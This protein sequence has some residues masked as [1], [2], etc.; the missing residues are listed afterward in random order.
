MEIS[1]EKFNALVKNLQLANEN[2]FEFEILLKESIDADGFKR[3]LSKLKRNDEYAFVE[4]INRKQLDIRTIGEDSAVRVS[5]YGEDNIINYCKYNIISENT[6]VDIIVK[7]RVNNVDSVFIDEYNLRG[8]VSREEQIVDKSFKL[9]YINKLGNRD[10]FF[11]YKER[12]TFTTKTHKI[13]LTNIKSTPPPGVAKRL[14]SSKTLSS[15]IETFEVEVEALPYVE[16]NVATKTVLQQILRTSGILLKANR[17][18]DLLITKSEQD[19]VLRE[20]LKLVNPELSKIN[21]DDVK[22]NPGR[23]YLR[24]Q[25]VTLMKKNLLNKNLENATILDDYSVTEKADGDRMLFFINQD[26]DVFKIDNKLKFVKLNIKHQQAGSTIIDGEFVEKGKLEILLNMYLAFDIYFLAGED[27]RHKNLTDRL[28]LLSDYVKS[29]KWTNNANINISVKTF[30]TEKSVFENT[31]DVFDKISSL[32]YHTDGLIFTPINLSPGALYKNDTSMDKFGGTWSKVF[33][34]KPPEENSID[35]LVRLGNETYIQT[36]NGN[37]QR[38]IYVDMF[39]AYKGNLEQNINIM[40]IYDRL[41]NKRN[42]LIQDVSSTVV[43]RF[44]DHTYLPVENNNKNPLTSLSNEIIVDDTIVEFSYNPEQTN[45]GFMKWIPMRVRKDKTALYKQSNKIEN[46]A[47][48][49]NTVTNVWHTIVDPVTKD[50]ITGKIT[51]N[52]EEVKQDTKYVYY[53]RDTPRHRYQSRPML[54]FHNFWVKK[55][56]LFDKFGSKSFDKEVKLLEI[57][58]GQGGDL[59]KW[60]DNKFSVVVGVDNNED[61]LLNSDHG[62]YKR[63]YESAH[64]DKSFKKLYVDKQS[65]IF[66]LL[67]AGEKWTKDYI[68]STENETLKTLSQIANG[69]IDKR[70][71]D[72]HLMRQMHDV[73]NNG[74]NVI[75]CQF[76]IHYFFES[77]KKLD[78]FCQNINTSLLPGGVFFGTALD[79]HIVNSEFTKTSKT[80]IQGVMNEKV[81]WQIEKKYDYFLTNNNSDENLGKQVD[82]YVETINKIIP[83]FLIDFE[84]LKRK[85]AEYNI[86][87]K[88]TG[89]FKELYDNLVIS[90]N[91]N[92]AAI[93]AIEGMTDELKHY[94]FMNRWFVFQKDT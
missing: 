57:G 80:K 36:P 38:C 49:Y 81:I 54:D 29:E 62:I 13:D 90:G 10:K 47:N 52:D 12:W 18:V 27:I 3:M 91:R 35:V 66:L 17:N 65:M 7:N 84:L 56:N 26:R 76:A 53:A 33:K 73:L 30:I 25:P 2:K 88:E 19:E 37:M 77:S 60:I 42:K 11:R 83:E 9:A 67:D 86:R 20:Y 61:N 4:A 5:L 94:S 78:A 24:Y 32:P 63:M 74:F 55:R 14:S 89:S 23:Y 59:Q 64:N 87:I 58:C 21:L 28:K 15:G 85:L 48:N 1:E 93:S 50:M 71:I 16:K 82:V 69:M 40:N 45:S 44:Y 31:R 72:N 79:G 75:S 43:K 92:W 39:V 6:N 51:L 68:N 70:R 34:W 41:N 22:S 46:T 8:N